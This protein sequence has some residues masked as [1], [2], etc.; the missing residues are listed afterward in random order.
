MNSGIGVV[1]V[2][3]TP[4]ETIGVV[5]VFITGI[6]PPGGQDVPVRTDRAAKAI[7]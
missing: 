5:V 2:T 3:L 7:L 1:A 4:T 6:K